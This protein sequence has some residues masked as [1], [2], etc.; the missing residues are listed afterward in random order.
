MHI[1]MDFSNS[2]NEKD[3]INDLNDHFEN[4]QLEEPI[5]VHYFDNDVMTQDVKG[6]AFFDVKDTDP[7]NII[8]SLE[9][10]GCDFSQEKNNEDYC[11]SST[12]HESISDSKS[13]TECSK[14]PSSDQKSIFSESL[15]IDAQDVSFVRESSEEEN[16][17]SDLTASPSP[18]LRRSKRLIKPSSATKPGSLPRRVKSKKSSNQRK[19]DVSASIFRRDALMKKAI[20]SATKMVKLH[21][22]D[23][24]TKVG[25]S[26]LFTNSESYYSYF[27]NLLMSTY[28]LTTKEFYQVFGVIC[29][30]TLK[31]SWLKKLFQIPDI[32]LSDDEKDEV[33][34]QVTRFEYFNKI[35]AKDPNTNEE[36]N[37]DSHLSNWREYSFHSAFMKVA[38]HMLRN[39][40]D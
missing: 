29:K 35:R 17:A 23:H 13:S 34:N 1:K 31:T 2:L 30:Q 18:S 11:N 38:V 5:N 10:R 19:T 25:G 22:I 3:D 33:V 6:I 14:N 9:E 4:I 27:K 26:D 15:E 40:S 36:Q 39:N 32:Y 20:R 7:L 8:T 21:F 28:D 37:T 24:M 16:K 12:R